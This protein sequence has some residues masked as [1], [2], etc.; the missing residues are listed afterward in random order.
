MRRVQAFPLNIISRVQKAKRKRAPG[1]KDFNFLIQLLKPPKVNPARNIPAAAR[2]H[3]SIH[4]VSGRLF[5]FFSLSLD[6]SY[7]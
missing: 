3:V 4:K 7:I 5:G 2:I 6:I 1:I